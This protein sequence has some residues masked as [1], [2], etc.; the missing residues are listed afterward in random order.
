MFVLHAG[1]HKHFG[2]R[3]PAH[4]V[5]DTDGSSIVGEGKHLRKGTGY[6]SH[7]VIRLKTWDGK[8]CSYFFCVFDHHVLIS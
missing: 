7:E 5:K 1:S 4:V 3:G 8:F 6:I 2:R